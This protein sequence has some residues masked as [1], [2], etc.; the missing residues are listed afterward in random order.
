M[1]RRSRRVWGDLK[2][3]QGDLGIPWRDNGEPGKT[4]GDM[5]TLGYSKVIL[6]RL[7]EIL[8]RLG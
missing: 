2:R 3:G 1:E 8:G 4:L 7:W 6:A 5:N